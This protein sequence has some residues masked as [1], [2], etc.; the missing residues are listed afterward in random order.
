MN[1]VVVYACMFVYPRLHTHNNKIVL[2]NKAD[3]TKWMKTVLKQMCNST[4]NKCVT[5]FVNQTLFTLE[6]IYSL[7]SE[8]QQK[9]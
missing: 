9:T 1:N 7:I 6:A 2:G 4:Q 3:N 5:P 8:S